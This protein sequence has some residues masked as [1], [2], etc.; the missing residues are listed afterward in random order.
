MRGA[1]ARRRWVSR[2]ACASAIGSGW[3]TVLTRSGAHAG[4]DYDQAVPW[5]A[6]VRI[7]GELP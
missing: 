5:F 2:P 1:E 6:L 4:R 3:R 7:S